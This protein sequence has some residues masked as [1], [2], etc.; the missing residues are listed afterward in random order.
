MNCELLNVNDSAKIVRN[1]LF[2]REFESHDD[3]C[4]IEMRQL[5]Y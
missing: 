5:I 2:I 3:N 4:K 1:A